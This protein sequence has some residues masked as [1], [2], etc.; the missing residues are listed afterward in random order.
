MQ[1]GLPEGNGP[2]WA[3]QWCHTLQH[4]FFN[5]P[6]LD[7]WLERC[8]HVASLPAEE[9]SAS[10]W[11]RLGIWRLI[12]DR[13]A[14]EV[15]AWLLS[16]PAHAQQLYGSSGF[17]GPL[18]REMHLYLVRLGY[19]DKSLRDDICAGFESGVVL[20]KTGLWPSHPKQGSL[21]KARKSS[22]DV[23]KNTPSNVRQWLRSRKPDANVAALLERNVAEVKR[24]RRI[25]VELD[26]CLDGSCAVHPEFSVTQAGKVRA[27][28]DCSVSGWND[29]TVSME[30][31]VCPSGDDPVDYSSR[32]LVQNPTCC[33]QV[34][35]A[36]EDSAYRN[37][38]T[39]NPAAMV[40]L[41]ML[42]SRRARAFKDYALCFGDKAGVY[43]YNRVRTFLTVFF[44]VEFAIAVWSYFD[45]SAIVERK[46]TMDF[47]WYAFLKVHTWLGIPIKGNPLV[48]AGASLGSKIFPPAASNKFLGE[49]LHVGS[50]PCSVAPTAARK[51]NGKQMIDEILGR[52]E[53]AQSMVSSV[54]SKLRFLGAELHGKCGLPALQAI[55]AHGNAGTPRLGPAVRSALLWLRELLDGVGPREWPWGSLSPNTLHIFGDASEPSAA[56]Q[57]HPMLAAV[58]VLPSGYLQTFAVQ[59]PKR[60][61]AMLPVGGRHIYY[62]ELLWP[63]LAVFIWRHL[64][65]DAYLVVYD[66]NEGAKFNLLRGFSNKFAS[67]LAL[68]FFWGAAAV[69]RSRPWI[70]RVA[71]ADNPADCLTKPGLSCRH[72]AGAA[73]VPSSELDEFW[74]FFLPCLEDERFPTWASFHK[75]LSGGVQ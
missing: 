72:L 23:F 43:A 38:A 30:K 3:V 44:R 20:P 51:H 17:N 66:D 60:L 35:V 50:L 58:L 10:R 21:L 18:F 1:G 36:D 24:G 5:M 25:E 13:C 4:P 31:L 68:A 59:V 26:S 37:W 34:A 57:L 64:L 28:N 19:P 22:E 39:K 63:V 14:N 45:D 61:Q 9:V 67:A 29:A 15:E 65:R 2:D 54:F 71:S 52:N 46:A 40:M 53:L 48:A 42:G 47:A 55:L 74:D 33:P 56:S 75:L 7:P 73:M 12:S 69:H 16:L 49:Q 41:V 32:L 70:A 27:C 11:T 62:Y 8:L 6:S